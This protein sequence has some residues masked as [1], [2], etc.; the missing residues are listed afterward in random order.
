MVNHKGFMYSHISMTAPCGDHTMAHE[1]GHNMG[2]T[3]SRRA[4]P[5]GGT[6]PYSVGYG[7]DGVFTTIM[8]YEEVFSTENTIYKFSSPDLNCYGTPCGIDSDIK[9]F[10]ADAVKTLRITT[11]QIANFYQSKIQKPKIAPIADGGKK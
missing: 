4:M 11:P 8:A 5:K 6:F 7:V 2:L 3:H 1:L 9:D 10:G